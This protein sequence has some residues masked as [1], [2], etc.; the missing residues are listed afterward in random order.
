M[1]HGNASIAGS[2]ARIL[3][4]G[5]HSCNIGVRGRTRL[6]RHRAHSYTA[7]P[8]WKKANPSFDDIELNE[9]YYNELGIS[10]EELADQLSFRATDSDPEGQ[11]IG[12]E[13]PVDGE[14]PSFLHDQEFDLEAWGPEVCKHIFLH[15]YHLR[16]DTTQAPTW[17]N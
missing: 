1:L 8:D 3:P 17:C 5:H 2:A 12:L 4:S 15:L 13:G 10:P 6:S 11:D 16:S 7:T 9:E 14:N